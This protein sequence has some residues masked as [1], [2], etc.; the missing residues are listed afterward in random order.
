[1]KHIFL[2]SG[3]RRWAKRLWDAINL[4]FSIQ[5]IINGLLSAELQTIT[6]CMGLVMAVVLLVSS[7]CLSKA[8]IIN[9]WIGSSQQEYEKSRILRRI[10]EFVKII[11]A[12]EMFRL[13][14]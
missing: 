7:V 3:D 1:M 13:L 2:S 9:L 14:M 5:G 8:T 11:A 10:L 12:I 4:F 6:G